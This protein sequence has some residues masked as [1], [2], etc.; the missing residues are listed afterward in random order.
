MLNG[1]LENIPLTP[2]MLIT[3]ERIAT[4]GLGANWATTAAHEFEAGGAAVITCLVLF[5]DCVR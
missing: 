2:V 3:E 4:A 1:S 5:D